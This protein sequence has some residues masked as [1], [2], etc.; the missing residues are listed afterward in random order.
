[1]GGP[2][3]GG[4]WAAGGQQ[5]AA[6]P[7]EVAVVTRRAISSY[8]ETNGAL[9]A[10]NEVDIVARTSGPIVQLTVEEG[11]LVRAGQTLA[12][13]DDR[14]ARARLEISRVTL[15]ETSLAYDRAQNLQRESLI[16]PEEYE[17]AKAA[18]ES[19]K[20]QVE[21]DEIQ[22]DYTQIQAPFEGLIITRYVKFAD[23][24]AVNEPLFRISDFDPLWLPIQV[25]ER[26]LSRLRV[27]QRAYLTVEPWPGERFDARVLRISPVVDAATGTIKV[28]LETR[29]QGKLR[30]GMFARVFVETAKKDDAL[31]IPKA[32]LSLESI[33]DTVYV[34]DGD[35]ASRREIELGFSEGEFI[36]ALSGVEE[37][38]RVVVVGQDGLSDGTPIQV[39]EKGETLPA[40]TQT[41][42]N[43]G[44]R[45][46]G[47]AG[48]GR[49]P[50]AGGPRGGPGEGMRAKG[51][52]G[53]RLD[54]SKMTPE[55]LERAKEFMRARGMTEEQIEERL[56]RAREQSGTQTQ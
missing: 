11:D 42:A 6:V 29:P 4:P 27:G 16:S 39:L 13:L 35:V 23:Q 47:G 28:T 52:G 33:G 44:D 37:G 26:E 54:P 7:V 18:Y 21:Q 20:A 19:A 36:E 17:R 38:E 31:V 49:A 9:E 15:N 50:G 56:R 45:P 3:G 32:A 53:R 8:I 22:L 14:E 24:V 46:G 10:V 1:M 43:G 12:R 48:E 41:M 51:P 2:G 40:P 30:P 55:Q 5:A 25:P 34:V